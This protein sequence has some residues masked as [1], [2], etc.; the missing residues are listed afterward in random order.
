MKEAVE[1]SYNQANSDRSRVNPSSIDR[2]V[3]EDAINKNKTIV[4]NGTCTRT[5]SSL[6]SKTAKRGLR[7]YSIVP[8]QIDKPKHVLG[9]HLLGFRVFFEIFGIY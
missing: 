2:R 5:A 9:F 8:I 6:R 3:K 7:T 4:M 1:I